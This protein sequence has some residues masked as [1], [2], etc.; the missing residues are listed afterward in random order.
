M[1]VDPWAKD[2]A[3]LPVAF[4]QVREDAL[5]DLELINSLSTKKLRILMV[6]SGGCTAC[7]L[8]S[9]PKVEHVTL[10][11]PNPAQLDLAALKLH[12]LENA[13]TQRRLEILGHLRMDRDARREALSDALAALSIPLG[14]FGPAED[15][16]ALGPDHVG[17]YERVFHQLRLAMSDRASDL[18]NLLRL[19]D[20]RAQSEAVAPETPLGKCLDEAFDS[21][22]SLDNLVEVF[23][24]AATSNRVQPF[25]QHFRQ[26]TRICLET[27]N[28]QGN[29]YLSQVFLG[30]YSEP[31]PWFQ[32]EQRAPAA[33][34]DALNT[35]ML[36]ALKTIDRGSYDLVHLSNILDWL[37]PDS[38]EEL[39]TQ[40]ARVLKKG[41][42]SIIRQ[43][44]STADVQGADCPLSWDLP[45]GQSLLERD[46]SFFY[47]AI[48]IG[49]KQ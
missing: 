44:N 34:I 31:A 24:V 6:A 19:N 41:G 18:E 48:H 2:I 7:V 14:R 27:L 13:A 47:R 30:R 25:S 32:L 15:T 43:L 17:R 5:G 46:R 36:S 45:L 16:V 37:S 12:L 38:V 49:K 20:T 39:L 11:D 26:R 22:F 1:A 40:T 8:A 23:G 35:D 33:S 3:Q 9:S 42:V 28:A 29:P 4:S 21:V 10:V